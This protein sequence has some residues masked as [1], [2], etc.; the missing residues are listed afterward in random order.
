MIDPPHRVL[1]IGELT[2]LI[3]NQLILINRGGAVDLA[4]TSRY[5]E[6]PV[7]STL[8]EIQD[9]LCTLLKMLP[10]DTWDWDAQEPTDSVVRNL[11][12]P[13]EGLNA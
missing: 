11:N 9:S 12:L 6:E 5:L 7:L 2:R 8:W 10:R 4:C 3:A 1:K 13:L